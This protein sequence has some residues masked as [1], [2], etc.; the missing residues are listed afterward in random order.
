MVHLLLTTEKTT[1]LL[2]GVSGPWIQCKCGLRQGDPLSPYLF[3]IVVDLLHRLVVHLKI[4]LQH[5]LVDDLPYP[6]VQYADDTLLIL[7][8]IEDQVQRLKRILDSFAAATILHINF[9]KKLL[10]STSKIPASVLNTMA[11]K[12][13][14]AVPGW[15]AALLS[16]TGWLTLAKSVL[17]A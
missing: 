13:E 2:N 12:A 17:M 7:R 6:V 14:R 1:V 15:R 10:L 11:I 9:H 5:P 4:S 16:R 8:A 3:L